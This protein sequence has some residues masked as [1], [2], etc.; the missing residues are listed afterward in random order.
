MMAPADQTSRSFTFHASHGSS[1]G[2]TKRSHDDYA[3][4]NSSDIPFF[5]SDDL[6]DASASKSASPRRKRQYRRAWFESEHPSKAH[7]HKSMRSMTKLPKDSGVYMNSDSSN[8]SSSS[9]EGFNIQNQRIASLKKT[10]RNMAAFRHSKYRPGSGTVAGSQAQP[11]AATDNPR[12][13]STF[14]HDHS[15]A[16]NIIKQCVDE[17]DEDVDMRFVSV[18]PFADPTSN[19]TCDSHQDLRLIHDAD[20]RSLQQIIREP[21]AADICPFTEEAYSE[22]TA[23]IKINLAHNRLRMLPPALMEVE[24]LVFLTIR[25]NNITELPQAIGRMWQLKELNV[26]CNGMRWLPWELMRIMGSNAGHLARFRCRPNPLFLPASTDNVTMLRAFGDTLDATKAETVRLKEV[27][28]RLSGNKQGN[29]EKNNVCLYVDWARKINKELH[30]RLESQPEQ[31]PLMRVSGKHFKSAPIWLGMTAITYFDDKGELV[32]NSPPAPSSLPEHQSIL[33]PVKS[34]S[35]ASMPSIAGSVAGRS[36]APS[37]KEACLR[38]CVRNASFKDIDNIMPADAPQA[39]WNAIERAK[40]TK[41]DYIT[42]CSVCWRQYVMPRAEWIEYWHCEPDS[43]S[44]TTENIAVPLLRRVCS[45]G[46]AHP[47]AFQSRKPF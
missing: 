29:K 45:W 18:L 24:N 9:F 23:Q 47:N 33:A 34:E 21:Q 5:S 8:A 44:C 16:H 32:P 14:V 41:D 46:C 4:S 19:S 40:R 22:L 26:S 12:N 7:T 37:L 1:F 10:E 25:N 17:N 27:K 42:Q 38:V 30:K 6:T 28:T 11:T 20:I 31:G 3:S 43:L 15:V 2:R 36:G 35:K 13:P 39:I